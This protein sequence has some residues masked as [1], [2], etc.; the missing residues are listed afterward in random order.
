ME[1]EMT[2]QVN[3]P[4]EMGRADV[5]AAAAI[6]PDSVTESELLEAPTDREEIAR[7]AYSYWQARGCPNGSPEEDWFCAERELRKQAVSATE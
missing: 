1:M 4:T 6:E 7:L 5:V 2:R 3:S